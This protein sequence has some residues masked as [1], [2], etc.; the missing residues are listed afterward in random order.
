MARREAIAVGGRG[1][2]PDGQHLADIGG[3]LHKE[4]VPIVKCCAL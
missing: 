2:T 4:M 1:V 3:R